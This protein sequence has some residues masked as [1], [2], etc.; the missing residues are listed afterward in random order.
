MDLTYGLSPFLPAK[1]L[2]ELR[3]LAFDIAQKSAALSG[4]PKATI[5]ALRGLLRLVNSYYSNLIEGQGTHPA[6]VERAV[7]KQAQ[8]KKRPDLVQLALVVA[9]VEASMPDY[10]R[11]TGA[12]PASREFLCWIH[13]SIYGALP[14]HM[15]DVQDRA[16]RVTTRLVPGEIR[17]RDVVVGLHEPMEAAKI[18]PAL[19]LFERE[20]RPGRPAGDLGLIAVAAAHHRLT[21]IHP[22]LD[23]NGRVAR[24][25]SHAHLQTVLNH[26][27]VWS[28]SRGL[29]RARKDYYANLA[30]A[31]APRQ[32]DYDGRGALS[33][34][35]LYAFCKF[36]LDT[37]LD[38]VNYMTR[39]L[40]LEGYRKRV[41]LF[42]ERASAGGLTDVPELDRAA[43]PVLA[44]LFAAGELSRADAI[45]LTGFRE[46][47]GRS[48]IAGIIKA[49]L[50]E[51]TS[52]RA[53]LRPRF[54]AL[55]MEDLFPRL[56]GRAADL[57]SD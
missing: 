19:E 54:P 8:R 43:A 35:G 22:F 2:E 48:V 24:L 39:V 17:D 7:R 29:A 34:G 9:E 14:D 51:S 37:C 5:D 52:H 11:K 23:G 13:G 4:K 42:A 10:L 18:R 53:P 47:K 36:F 49:G 20:Y 32:G 45:A 50:A 38:Q 31:D 44:M 28:L 55:F 40:E 1:G 27:P 56:A 15:L 41:E 12:A 57:G 16:E 25:F 26:V 6:D 3:A 46:R 30:S 33:D 21:W